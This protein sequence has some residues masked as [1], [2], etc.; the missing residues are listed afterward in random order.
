MISTMKKSR[1]GSWGMECLNM[2][3]MEDITE[4]IAFEPRL[5]GDEGPKVPG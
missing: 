3:A 5:K 1:E 4:K 2:V